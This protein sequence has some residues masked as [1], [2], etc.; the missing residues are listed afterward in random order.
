[1]ILW[2]GIVLL[3]SVGKSISF[4]WIKCNVKSAMMLFLMARTNSYFSRDD[5]IYKDVQE[6]ASSRDE[7]GQREWMH[8]ASANSNESSYMLLT[9]K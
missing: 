8:V 2:N 7:L 6:N 5:Q 9:C 4:K 3:R 1:M